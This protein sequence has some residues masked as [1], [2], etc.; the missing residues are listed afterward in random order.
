M[1]AMKE[2]I[3]AAHGILPILEVLESCSQR[4]VVCN[5]LKIINAVCRKP[6]IAK[7]TH[8]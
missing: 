8:S 2:T 1:P 3:I 7:E 5:L 4:D 6:I